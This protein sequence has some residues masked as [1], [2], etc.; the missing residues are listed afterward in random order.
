[1]RNYYIF[2]LKGRIEFRYFNDLERFNF[3]RIDEKGN[4]DYWINLFV[5]KKW[6][7]IYYVLNYKYFIGL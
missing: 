7:K 6:W 5:G 2:Y 3:Y 4:I 1:M